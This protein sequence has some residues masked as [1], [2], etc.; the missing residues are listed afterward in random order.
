MTDDFGKKVE[1]FGQ[2]IWRK[3]QRTFDIV[4]I[5][6][7]IGIK[8]RRLSE[9]YAE[10][11]EAYCK[12]HQEDAQTEFP[13][14]CEE[15][16]SLIREIAA[17][18]AAVLRTKG[19]RECAACHAMV[20]ECAAYCPRCGAAMPEPEPEPEP[21]AEAHEADGMHCGECGASLED[22]DHYCSNCGAKRD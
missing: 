21:A 1:A 10:I 11:G 12:S 5:N 4:S 16:I 19:Y 7:D 9:L 14:F 2:N 17:L 20:D 13:E 8:E 15:A 6:N 22:D 3:A 18:R